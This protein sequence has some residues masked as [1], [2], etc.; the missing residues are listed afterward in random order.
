MSQ[1]GG[2]EEVMAS[3]ARSQSARDS[4]SGRKFWERDA[5]DSGRRIPPGNQVRRSSANSAAKVWLWQTKQRGCCRK[6]VRRAAANPIADSWTEF[7][8]NVSFFSFFWSWDN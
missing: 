7:Q 4:G 8:T 3:M 1:G 6:W 5:G 2:G